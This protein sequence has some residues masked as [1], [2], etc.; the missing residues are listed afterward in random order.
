MKVGEI[1]IQKS[2]PVRY[3]IKKITYC[4][5]ISWYEKDKSGKKRLHR[6]YVGDYTIT[7]VPVRQEDQDVELDRINF[8]KLFYR[9]E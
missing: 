7:F 4:K 3:I 9:E 5:F 8:L 1:W 2:N 6:S